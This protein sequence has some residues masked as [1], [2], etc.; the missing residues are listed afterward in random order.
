MREDQKKAGDD[1]E[2]EVKQQEGS[3]KQE[4][5]DHSGSKTCTQLL[6]WQV[7]QPERHEGGEAA[8]EAVAPSLGG[9]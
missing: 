5:G 3:E 9:A 1:E 8:E 6:H 2:E 7:P 4:I